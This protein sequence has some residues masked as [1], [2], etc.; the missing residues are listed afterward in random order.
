MRFIVLLA[1]LIRGGAPASLTNAPGEGNCTQCHNSY[2]LDSTFS[3]GDNMSISGNFT[4]GGYIPDSSYTITLAHKNSS[5]NKFGFQL[6]C[7]D[8]LDS[9]AGSFTNTSTRTSK[10]SGSSTF[11]NREYMRQ[12]ASGTSGTGGSISWSFTWKAPSK[13]LGAVTFYAVLNSANGSGTANDSISVRKFEITP[14][15]L[16]PDASFTQ[17]KATIC[18]GD[19]VSFMGSSSDTNATY[20]WSFPNGGTKLINT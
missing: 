1:L 7:L 8:G 17:D 20:A 2:G 14:S 9:M 5:R 12:R 11:A 15:S 4:G 16:L 13:N 6:T 3:T 19:T 18:A 10:I